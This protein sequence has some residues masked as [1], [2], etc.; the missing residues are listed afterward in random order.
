MIEAFKFD[1]DELTN[2]EE[3]TLLTPPIKLL[4]IVLAT[5]EFCEPD[6]QI[7]CPEPP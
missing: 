2:D 1:I 6:T 3:T 5:F 7:E 4:C